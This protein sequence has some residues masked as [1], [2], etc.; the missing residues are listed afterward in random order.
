MQTAIFL[1]EAI[2]SK[3]KILLHSA[4]ARFF[5]ILSHV[6]NAYKNVI[7]DERCVPDISR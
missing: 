7:S 6:C 4:E 5:K 2:R 3:Q 1:C